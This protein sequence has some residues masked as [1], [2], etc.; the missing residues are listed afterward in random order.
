MSSDS[1]DDHLSSSEDEEMDD[2]DLTSNQNDDD[3]D[4]SSGD[5]DDSGN[6]Y[7]AMDLG[8]ELDEEDEELDATFRPKT[9]RSSRLVKISIRTAL[10]ALR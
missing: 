6:L 7:M 5:S 4:G 3:D 2:E 10:Q 1:E 9:R 8:G